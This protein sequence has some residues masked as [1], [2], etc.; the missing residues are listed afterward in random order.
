M[1][2]FKFWKYLWKFRIALFRP[3]TTA[4]QR[5][6]EPSNESP[7]KCCRLAKV[8]PVIALFARQCRSRCS[9]F[10]NRAVCFD[11][12]MINKWALKSFPSD[13]SDISV[14]CTVLPLF[15]G[16]P[17]TAMSFEAVLSC[18]PFAVRQ[19]RLCVFS[20]SLSAI[21]WLSIRRAKL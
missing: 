21:F 17:C 11:F 2:N 15:L 12:L 19:R 10:D 7:I 4:S 9:Y 20:L 14:G 6:E 1:T 16:S 3:I 8:L 18:V 5:A 13:V